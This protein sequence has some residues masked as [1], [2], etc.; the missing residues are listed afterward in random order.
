MK[1][2]RMTA[3]AVLASLLALPA[4]AGDTVAFTGATLHPVSAPPV[5]GTLLVEDGKIVAAGPEVA[6][7]AGARTVELAGKHVYPSL[8]HPYSA[9]GLIEIS[10][11]R[12]TVDASEIGEL[13]ANI[14]AEVAFHADSELLPV[15]MS[16]GILVAN[17]APRG[18]LFRGTSALMR[19]DGWNW[20]DMTLAAP[21]GMHLAFPRVAGGD[22]DNDDND[23]DKA[24]ELL[25]DTLADARAYDQARRAAE[26]GTAPAI[27][28]DPKLEALR[29]LLAGELP[30]FVHADEKKQIE[31][32]LDWA[33]EEGFTNLVLITGPDARYLAGRLAEEEVPVVLNGV[34]LRPERSWEPYDSS[35]GAAAELHAAGVRFCIGD[36]GSTFEAANARN[37]PFHAAMAAAFGLPREVALRSVTLSVAEILGMG[38]RLGS[39]E[40]GKDATFIVTDGDPLEIVTRIEAAWLEGREVDLSRD[41]Q[42]RLYNRYRNRPAPAR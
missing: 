9:L 26:A 28:I 11:V 39:L 22:D 30:L 16:G 6:V 7:P 18:G 31:A 29:P 36:G 4:A 34:L 14:R 33:E 35:Y 38:E 10:S 1:R 15:A 19:L 12:G 13:N 25:D 5:A 2:S 32:A 41:R 20:Q 8:I 17:V 42:K 3:V 23:N 21:V 37:L 24:L 27:A 40:P